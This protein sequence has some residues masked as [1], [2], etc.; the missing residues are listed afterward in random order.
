MHYYLARALCKCIYEYNLILNGGAH[1]VGPHRWSHIALMWVGKQQKFRKG[2]RKEGK[3]RK[4]KR[5]KRSVLSNHSSSSSAWPKPIQFHFRFSK[6]S[7]VSFQVFW[8]QSSFSWPIEDLIQFQ[9][10]KREPVQHQSTPWSKKTRSILLK[11]QAVHKLVLIS[12][13]TGSDFMIDVLLRLGMICLCAA[14]TAGLP[15]LTFNRSSQLSAVVI[16]ILLFLLTPTL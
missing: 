8:N 2:R 9:L 10:R 16:H 12:V 15:M 11:M 13:F 5:K 3:K 14:C 4:E 6:T 7:P 1:V